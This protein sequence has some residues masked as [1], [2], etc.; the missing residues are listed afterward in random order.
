MT[1]TMNTRGRVN[2]SQN[3]AAVISEWSLDADVLDAAE[4]DLGLVGHLADLDVVGGA[5]GVAAADV[6][7]GR[8]AEAVLL[9][10]RQAGGHR[11]EQA[12]VRHSVL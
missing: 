5:A 7:D 9:V 11:V 3:F 10:L 4:V 1:L 8:H 12:G 6:V 2:L